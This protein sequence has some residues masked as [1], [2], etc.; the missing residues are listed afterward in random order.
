MLVS[1]AAGATLQLQCGAWASRQW[2]LLLRFPDSVVVVHRGLVAPQ[3]VGSSQTR[4][5]THVPYIGR[6]ILNHWTA[7]EVPFTLLRG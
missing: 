7:R 1:A 5:G 3:H 4:N 2:L 6:R